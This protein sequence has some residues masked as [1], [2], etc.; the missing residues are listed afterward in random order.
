M[1]PKQ[2]V[3]VEIIR[4]VDINR[5]SLCAL[6]VILKT[7][8]GPCTSLGNLEFQQ[9]GRWM[10]LHHLRNNLEWTLSALQGA[11]LVL[12]THVVSA[13]DFSFLLGL[14]SIR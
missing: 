5:L 1:R 14:S 13:D 4:T 6:R 10:D 12:T 3:S 9:S 7:T 2:K 8:S 11:I